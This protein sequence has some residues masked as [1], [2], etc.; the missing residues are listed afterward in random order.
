MNKKT[1]KIL[2]SKCMYYEEKDC[3]PVFVYMGQRGQF[4]LLSNNK[5]G[6]GNNTLGGNNI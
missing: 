6:W 3:V 5:K 1:D 4:E 2:S